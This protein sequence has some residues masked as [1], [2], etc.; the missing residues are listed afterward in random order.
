MACAAEHPAGRVLAALALRDHEVLELVVAHRPRLGDRAVGLERGR[1][2]VDVHQRRRHAGIADRDPDLPG[3]LPH[4]LA[5]VVLADAVGAGVGEGLHELLTRM[6]GIAL[7]LPCELQ[8]GREA[9]VG[10]PAI[11]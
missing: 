11:W 2:G 5:E 8:T 10:E 7:P 9:R 1:G 3:D 4:R 6:P